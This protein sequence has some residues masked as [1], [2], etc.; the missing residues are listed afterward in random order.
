LPLGAQAIARI[1]R[2]LAIKS[3]LDFPHWD[4][5]CAH[6][7]ALCRFKDIQDLKIGDR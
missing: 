5:V 4:I 7:F 2:W 1:I 3:E 6:S